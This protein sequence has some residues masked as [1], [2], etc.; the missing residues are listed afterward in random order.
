MNRRQTVFFALGAFALFLGYFILVYADI[1]FQGAS[2]VKRDVQRYYYPMWHFAREGWQAGQVHFWNPYHS[3][4]KPFV[5]NIQNCVFYPF[6]IILALPDYTQAFGVYVLFHLALAGV[7]TALWMIDLGSSRTAALASGAAFACSGYAISS[8]NLTISL[9]SIV[10][11]PLALLC[12][13]RAMRDGAFGWRVGLGITMLFQYLAGD[14]SIFFSTLVV[15]TMATAGRL[16]LLYHQNRKIDVRPVL[17]L[18]AGVAVFLGLGAFHYPLFYQLLKQST[19]SMI[20]YD[21]A[22]MWSVQFND[23]L[24]LAVPFFSDLSVAFM[25]YWLRQSWLESY[26]AGI[27]VLILAFWAWRARRDDVAG[28]HVLLFLFGVSLALG[29]FSGVYWF[30]NKFFPFFGLIRYPVRFFYISY[31][32][33]ACLAGFG[34]DAILKNTVPRRPISKGYAA[35]LAAG[36]VLLYA[37]YRWALPIKQ[38]SCVLMYKW[39]SSMNA[40][41]WSVPLIQD[42]TIPLVD[43]LQRTFLLAMATLTG[44]AV[45]RMKLCR[46]PLLAAFFLCLIAADLGATSAFEFRVGRDFIDRS[47]SHLNIV[48]KDPELF[49]VFASP[50]LTQQQ[51]MPITTD[52]SDTQDLIVQSFAPNLLMTSHVQDL[53]G[54]DSLHLT[55]TSYLIDARFHVM[56]PDRSMFYAFMNAKYFVSPKKDLGPP[57]VLVNESD[58][59]TLYRDPRVLPRAFLVPRAEV[60][61]DKKRIADR[62][63]SDDFKPREVVYLM[64]DPGWKGPE[65]PPGEG[66]VSVERYEPDEVVMRVESPGPRWLFFSDAWYPG[67]RAWIDGKPVPVEQ[68]NVAFRAVRVGGGSHRVVWKYDTL[69]FKIGLMVSLLTA[70]GLFTWARMRRGH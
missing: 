32:A 17:R 46:G 47:G 57:F 42:M 16:F 26:Y 53:T 48:K 65:G 30:F 55:N 39:L 28:Y 63:L 66:K 18:A 20:E 51:N 35:A 23:L 58:K 14:P 5:A 25:D 60:V 13:R 40:S 10:Y 4:G 61:A 64:K 27:T 59:T 37:G 19:R 29:K 49:R 9:C 56:H 62:L 24:G 67:W 38:Q 68:A 12:W 36:M 8:I 6:Q 31:F 44:I 70:T 21:L 7:T 15:L 52:I 43:N 41:G 33:L 3:L 2:F 1:V 22:T 11:L 34:V 45:Y 50:S 69:L 54:Y